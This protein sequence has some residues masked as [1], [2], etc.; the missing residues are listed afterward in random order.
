MFYVL[1]YYKDVKYNILLLSFGN[2]IFASTTYQQI[3]K[4]I[5]WKKSYGKMQ[6]AKIQ[7][8]AVKSLRK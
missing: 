3:E 8:I 6:A 1:S 7:N 2:V 5:K 4:G